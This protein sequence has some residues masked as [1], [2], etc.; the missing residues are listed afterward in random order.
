MQRCVIAYAIEWKVYLVV[1]I[2][3]AGRM[4]AIMDL[5]TDVSAKGIALIRGTL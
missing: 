1:D 2:F 4:T 3:D 5:K